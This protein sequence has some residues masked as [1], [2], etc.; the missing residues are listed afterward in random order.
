MTYQHQYLN[1]I[2]DS[3]YNENFKILWQYKMYIYDRK[4]TFWY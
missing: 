3:K 1:N 2:N 4:I